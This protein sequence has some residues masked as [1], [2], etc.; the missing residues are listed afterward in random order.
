MVSLFIT[1]NNSSDEPLQKKEHT[2]EYIEKEKTCQTNKNL[3][4]DTLLI[5]KK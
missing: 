5:E 3:D 1:C 2:L 4:A